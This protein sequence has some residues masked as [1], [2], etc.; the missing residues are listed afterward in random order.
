MTQPETVHPLCPECGENLKQ[1]G[2]SS[3]VVTTGTSN[4]E[5]IAC[6]ACSKVFGVFPGPLIPASKESR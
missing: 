5:V 6:G 3:G 4:L 1:V 2:V